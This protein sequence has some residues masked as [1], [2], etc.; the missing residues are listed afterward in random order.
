MRIKY[1]IM[2]VVFAIIFILSR[3]SESKLGRVVWKEQETY[4]KVVI[5]DAGHGG[6]D[7]GAVGVTGV[8][9][10]YITLSISKKA[11]YLCGFLGINSML[12]REDDNS[13]DYN[14]SSNT[15][16]NKVA[17][18]RARTE[19]VNSTANAFLISVHLNSFTDEQYY[20][21]QIFY[22]NYSFSEQYANILQSDIKL[23][24]DN[25]NE[26]KALIAPSSVYLIENANCPAVIY[27]CGFLSNE[28]EEQLLSNDGYQTKLAICAVSSYL[29]I[30]EEFENETK[31]SVLVL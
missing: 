14:L 17:D 21:A 28:T 29:K 26:R 6:E 19:L 8:C 4:E 1:I 5:W 27:E 15:R 30:Q 3:I 25:A 24:L 16:E 18:T 20:G 10:Q 23:H 13:L 9:E 7:G 2:A 22:N 11:D 31:N 12:T